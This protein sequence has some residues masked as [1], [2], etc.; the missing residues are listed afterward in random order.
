M[1][2]RAQQGEQ[3]QQ[4]Q[5]SKQLAPSAP[6]AFDVRPASGLGGATCGSLA[7]A[8]PAAVM[9]TLPGASPQWWYCAQC[10]L[11]F[12]AGLCGQPHR[13]VFA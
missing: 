3:G 9:M 13:V 8:E 11:V 12:Y 10:W 1:T 6:L 7:C 2:V 4:D 5:Q